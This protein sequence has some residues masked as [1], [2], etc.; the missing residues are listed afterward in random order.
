MSNR[1]TAQ[2]Q[3]PVSF[4]PVGSG[5]LQRKC[6]CG[7]HTT[8]GGE[9]G[10]CARKKGISQSK[11][12]LQNEQAAVPPIV[13]EV[14]GSP[15]QP[16][17]A[18]TRNFMEP[19]FG[20]D[21]FVQ[22]PI[23]L[24]PLPASNLTVGRANDRR[25]SEAEEA[26]KRV[27]GHAEAPVSNAR[28]NFGHVQ[29]HTGMRAAEA[30][31]S[32][33][34]RAFTV[35]RHVV[36]DAN[37]FRPNTYEGKR[38]L[39]HE[40]AHVVQ[41]T[42]AQDTQPTTIRRLAKP[43]T[44]TDQGGPIPPAPNV[45][46]GD[47][48]LAPKDAGQTDP[49]KQKDEAK[50]AQDD[51][52]ES[53]AQEQGEPGKT[54]PKT[55]DE[56][57]ADTQANVGKT[58]DQGNK[59]KLEDIPGVDKDKADEVTGSIDP[60][61]AAELATGDLA[62]ID[63]ELAEHQRWGAAT[64]T[65]GA[66]GSG[67]R[68]KFIAEAASGGAESGLTEGFTQGLKMGV[69]M[70]V[71]EKLVEKGIQK[72]AIAL[73]ARLGAQAGKFTPL[74]GVG[75]AIG[76]A[77]AA[78]DLAS[79]DWKATGETLGRFGKGASIY[80]QL[81]N[82]IEAISTT[83]EVATQILNVIAG[84]L[85]AIT[86]VMWIL[87]VVTVGVMSPVAATLTTISLA[88]GIATM[89]LDAINALVIKKLIM[90][91][92][93]LHAFTS[94]AD[95]RDVVVQGNAIGQA[96][97]AATG[98]VGG[99]AGG[100]ALDVGSAAVGKGLKIAKGKLSSPV[101]EHQ[102][103][104]TAGGEGPTVK[105]EPSESG[106]V[107]KE[108]ATTATGHAEPVSIHPSTETPAAL[109]APATP[110]E[111]QQLVLPGME[112][113]TLKAPPTSPAVATTAP[114]P[115]Q[116]T[117]TGG[118]LRPITAPLELTAIGGNESIPRG[119]EHGAIGT[120]GR[121][122]AAPHPFAL[123]SNPPGASGATRGGGRMPQTGRQD[124]GV[125]LEHQTPAS[126][127]HEVLPGH[128][129]H[130]PQG[131]RRGGR[132]T[133]EALTISFPESVKPFKDPLDAALLAEVRARKAQ[134][135]SVPPIEITVRGAQHSQAA[136]AQSGAAVPP[137]QISKA[138]LAEIDQFHDPRFGY[139][140]VRIGEPLPAGHPLRDASAAEI[141][142][143]VDRLF[144]PYT[145]PSGTQLPL[146][147]MEHLAPQSSR[148]QPQQLA[149]RGM[150]Q[151]APNP[152]QLDL[153]SQPIN[154][155]PETTPIPQ[156]T[157]TQQF[158]PAAESTPASQPKIRIATG[159][160]SQTKPTIPVAESESS[161]APQ[162]EPKIRIATEEQEPKVRVN[163]NEAALSE[164]E[165]EALVI[166]ELQQQEKMQK[167]ALQLSMVSRLRASEAQSGEQKGE[168]K[169]EWFAGLRHN[170]KEYSKM[171]FSAMSTAEKAVYLAGGPAAGAAGVSFMRGFEQGRN[172]PVI[173]HVNPNY[174]TPP[175]TPQDLVNMQNDILL[176]LDA[177]AQAE[178]T[179]KAAA[180][181]VA[182]HKA[183]EKP[184][185]KMQKGTEEAISATE[186][187]KQAV[188]RRKEAT[189]KKKDNEKQA[190]NT[191]SDYTNRAAELS[192]ITVP[193][194]AFFRF[195]SLA[196]SL[197]DTL[198]KS[199]ADT[200]PDFA[201]TRAD[202]AL[203]SGKRNLIK[204]NKDSQNFLGQLDSMNK[205]VNAQK[206]GQADRE[207]K[208]QA[209]AATLDQTNAKAKDSDQSLNQAKQG[210]EDL[211]AQNKSRVDEAT[212]LRTEAA[213]TSGK[214]D[215]QAQMKQT[216]AKSLAASLQA[217]A[218]NHKQARIT[219]LNQT[220]ESLEKKGYRITEVKEL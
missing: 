143:H 97:G 46:A 117:S 131:Q 165:N 137:Q 1:Q 219:A 141:N 195:S 79:R 113:P 149:L 49:S 174:P 21:N 158:T 220:K 108:T 111:P 218:Q 85:G 184:L 54:T 94:E 101:P 57:K 33:D 17:D 90:M 170:A 159:E 217:W 78:Y 150:D 98:F 47:S 147:G 200:M 29:I 156:P 55:K 84:I 19:R 185:D 135:E 193:M 155:P 198:P 176:T 123:E 177:R 9:C 50:P 60:K 209:D 186:A 59:P 179:S 194:Q 205:T 82:S 23:N 121:A 169:D 12:T 175:G 215:A 88:I 7:N 26:A 106:T 148:P 120:Y 216:Q 146:P 163:D 134:G 130:G 77:L 206:A 11:I 144:H 138:F 65:V 37:E 201:A 76:G 129:Y 192:T 27:L 75:A 116:S 72:G 125:Y 115:A 187:H 102:T 153:F 133:L 35:G 48:G 107:T 70:K 124:A 31:R 93:A 5:L 99:L 110:V 164:A 73:A 53:D 212:K 151:P 58:P 204:M 139:T 182:H 80:D 96:A 15:G 132:D 180:G 18:E 197:P 81:A 67:Q 203:K 43:E 89:I 109:S 171:S 178:A 51:T 127:A 63:K 211:D 207:Q 41:Q 188:E 181:Q 2:T 30:A 52:Q 160:T 71:A 28:A 3:A 87:S 4:T 20:G 104:P 118:A 145:A 6:E 119:L 32:V 112:A 103:P 152:N 68:A 56:V 162:S 42:G 86:V 38:I 154:K 196:Y 168:K 83:L 64:A 100:A 105:A 8:A 45:Q 95:P 44:V 126:V 13:H 61:T 69:G 142:A 39:A 92:R 25:E 122:V 172:E 189:E 22:V 136:V 14:L 214:L 210:T 36:F 161:S 91:F 183:N 199:I 173:E 140:E 191:L 202:S 40:L 190:G 157:P 16:L 128:E 74:P 114:P 208:T 66:S 24:S 62:L 213:Q 166:E 10:E 34:S 167:K